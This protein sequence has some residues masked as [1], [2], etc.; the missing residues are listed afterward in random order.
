MGTKIKKIAV[1]EG[2]MIFAIINPLI[3]NPLF[4]IIFGLGAGEWGRGSIPWKYSPKNI[5][6][7]T[8]VGA[9]NTKK[10]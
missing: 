8:K 1:N 2:D 5:S 9:T 3:Q 6:P 10:K 7:L 4:K